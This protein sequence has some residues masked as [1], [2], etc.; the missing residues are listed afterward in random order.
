MTSNRVNV[1]ATVHVDNLKLEPSN[2]EVRKTIAFVAQEESLERTATPRESIKFSAKLRLPKTFTNDQLD[3]LCIRMLEELG[4]THCADTVIGGGLLKGISGG[5]KKRTS[6]GVELVV[7]PSLVYLDEPTS[8][9]DS[10]SA[11]QLCQVLKKVANAGASVLFT[12]HQPSSEIFN[13]FD[14]LI[15]MNRGRV[16]YQGSVTDV[17][18]YFEDRGYPI[19]ANFSTADWIMNVS[20][21]NK[22]DKLESKGFFDSPEQSSSKSEEEDVESSIQE[23]AAADISTD[24]ALQGSHVSILTETAML[25]EREI[26]ALYRDTGGTIARFAVTAF[27]AT[28]LGTIFFGVGR[29]NLED[30]NNLFSSFG[31]L[32]VVGIVGMMGSAQSELMA[33]P[34]TRPV[35][36]REY[37]TNHY[38]VLSYF[39]A[40]FS[41]EATM[42]AIQNLVLVSLFLIVFG[43]VSFF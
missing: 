7:K 2:I 33:F 37:S 5:E 23:I 10:F 25:Y 4:L 41:I 30:R 11:I 20:Q 15:L 8:G 9:L 27:L 34:M 17:S 1:Q 36:L 42:T 32:V 16:M 43:A 26:K 35:F 12:I 24:C 3:E 38:S 28:L 19:P 22:V 21:S 6:V 14:H 13:S 29:S 18:S 39:V 31:A 40:R